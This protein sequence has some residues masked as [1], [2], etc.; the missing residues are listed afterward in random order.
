[1]NFS[2]AISYLLNHEY[3]SLVERLTAIY[4]GC[5]WV[6]TKDIQSGIGED[7]FREMECHVATHCQEF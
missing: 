7:A 4:E 2:Q 1:M 3:F 5:I 6:N